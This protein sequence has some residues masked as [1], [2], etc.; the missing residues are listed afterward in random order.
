[1]DIARALMCGI[2]G[3]MFGFFWAIYIE[4][5]YSAGAVTFAGILDFMMTKGGAPE[6]FACNAACGRVAGIMSTIDSSALR[7]RNSRLCSPDELL[8][9]EREFES[10]D[11]SNGCFIDLD[12]PLDSGSEVRFLQ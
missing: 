7:G 1:M 3:L 9:Y 2:P 12:E 5:V 6:F 4:R 8:R 11:K 10:L